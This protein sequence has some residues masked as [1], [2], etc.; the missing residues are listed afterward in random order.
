M[1]T[2][3]V[4]QILLNNQALK[5][6]TTRHTLTEQMTMHFVQHKRFRKIITTLYKL[7][8]TQLCIKFENYYTKPKLQREFSQNE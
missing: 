8:G 7:R 4:I 6:E 3:K 2:Q 1:I 5:P